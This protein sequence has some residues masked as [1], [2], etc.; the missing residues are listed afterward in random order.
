MGGGYGWRVCYDLRS[1]SWVG[2]WGGG[3]CVGGGRIVGRDSIL[4]GERGVVMRWFTVVV[5]YSEWHTT[6]V[7][8]FVMLVVGCMSLLPVYV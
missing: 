3:R 5:T 6:Y 7:A 1:D 2:G 4:R 8:N